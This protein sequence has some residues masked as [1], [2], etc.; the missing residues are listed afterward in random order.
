MHGLR[1]N[2]ALFWATVKVG[3]RRP[4]LILPPF[5]GTPENAGVTLQ[6]RP[7]FGPREGKDEAATSDVLR[8]AGG[9]GQ[10]RGGTASCD[11]LPFVG[12]LR[13]CRG[14][15]AMVASFGPPGRQGC[16]GHF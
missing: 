6:F 15:I 11:F 14:Y 1:S 12:D 2:S 3:V 4:L 8:F 9:P 10:C 5:L 7:V 16:G 13:E